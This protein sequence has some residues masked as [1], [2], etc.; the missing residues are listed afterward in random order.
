VRSGCT[1]LVSKSLALAGLEPTEIAVLRNSL[2][3]RGAADKLLGPV[4]P[5]GLARTMT[6]SVRTG[7]GPVSQAAFDRTPMREVRS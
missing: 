5:T 7:F 1:G 4:H 3:T 2:R 6:P